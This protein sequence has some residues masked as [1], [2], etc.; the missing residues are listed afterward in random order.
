[1]STQLPRPTLSKQPCGYLNR[2][3]VLQ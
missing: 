3:R 2:R 1:M